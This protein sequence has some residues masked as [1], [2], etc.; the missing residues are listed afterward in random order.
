M[1]EPIT[2]ALGIKVSTLVAGFAGGLVSMA[3][4]PPSAPKSQ[5][6]FSV[7]VGCLSAGW[8][9]PLALYK[10]DFPPQ[11]ENGIGFLIGLT[12]MSLIPYILRIAKARAAAE[13]KKDEA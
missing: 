13:A 1:S 8:V 6:F 9:T 3:F 11:I 10:F 4:M 2:T 5:V 12:A 7:L